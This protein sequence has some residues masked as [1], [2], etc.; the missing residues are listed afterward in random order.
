MT[1]S[2]GYKEF[3]FYKW[4][5]K[6]YIDKTRVVNHHEK[7]SVRSLLYWIIILVL[8]SQKSSNTAYL[9]NFYIRMHNEFLT[10]VLRIHL[11]DT[12]SQ[13]S[14]LKQQKSKHKNSNWYEGLFVCYLG[15]IYCRCH[16]CKGMGFK[17]D[18]LQPT[19]DSANLFYSTNPM[20]CVW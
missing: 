16:H 10:E 12:D 14:T 2:N 17:T 9:M 15:Y 19:V 18:V 3:V 6:S 5:C 8:K 4:I 11:W 7:F 1:L 20:E 13:K